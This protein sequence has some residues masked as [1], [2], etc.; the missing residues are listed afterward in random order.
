M[1]PTIGAAIR[2]MTSEPVPAPIMIGTRPAMITATVIAFGRTRMHR[3]L[4]D[5][6]E[7]V[8]FSGLTRRQRGSQACFR[9]S[10]MITPNSADTPASAMKPT[11]L[12]TDRLC[13][14]SHN[15]QAPPARA[16]GRVAMINAPRR[17]A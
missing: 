17:S 2:C 1:P 12:A 9:Y 7:Q 8:A 15:S 3:A 10:S 14:S 5:R 13:P 11:P 16:N 6:V 4:A